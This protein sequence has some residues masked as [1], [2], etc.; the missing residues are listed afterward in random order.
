MHWWKTERVF[1]DDVC[2]AVLRLMFW[3]LHKR[4]VACCRSPRDANIHCA[5][6]TAGGVKV[7]LRWDGYTA[8]SQSLPHAPCSGW[9]VALWV[10]WPNR[11]LEREPVVDWSA[12][13]D[14]PGSASWL[15]LRRNPGEHPAL[16]CELRTSR[17]AG[18]GGCSVHLPLS[19]RGRSQ[20]G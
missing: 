6:V 8:W 5:S 15:S 18:E 13:V 10:F 16:V 12:L 1:V 11:I 7:S 3:W 20:A 14:Y 9:A 17:C 19:L 4:S 2:G